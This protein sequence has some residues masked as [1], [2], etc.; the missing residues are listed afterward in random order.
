MFTQDSSYILS[1]YLVLLFNG[2]NTKLYSEKLTKD[3][4]QLNENI[5]NNKNNMIKK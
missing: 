5:T 2:Y 3:I 1:K 4:K